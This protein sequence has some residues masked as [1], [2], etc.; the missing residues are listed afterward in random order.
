MTFLVPN[1]SNQNKMLIRIW[2]L[3]VFCLVV[4]KFI[5][6][7]LQIRYNNHRCKGVLY[8]FLRGYAKVYFCLKQADSAFH[9]V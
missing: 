9:N 5:D 4:L 8:A 2:F 3:F 1:Q 7:H 6:A